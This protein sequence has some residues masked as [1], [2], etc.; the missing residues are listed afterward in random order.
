MIA[1]CVLLLTVHSPLR[2]ADEQVT[3]MSG[4]GLNIPSAYGRQCESRWHPIALPKSQDETEAKSVLKETNTQMG[5]DQYGCSVREP[6]ANPNEANGSGQPR[7]K[8]Y[9]SSS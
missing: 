6:D 1:F 4:N 2:M 7:A 8:L 9:I 5:L 3:L